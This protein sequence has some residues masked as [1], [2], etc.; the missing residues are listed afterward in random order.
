MAI[1]CVE[2]GRFERLLERHGDRLRARLFSERELEF[3]ALR[4]GTR[5]LAARFA[6]KVAARRALGIEDGL[7]GFLEV[8]V[9][10]E[11]GAAPELVLRGGAERAAAA[12]GGVRSWVSLTH[13]R[14][15]GV[16]QVLFERSV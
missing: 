12:F 3:A 6:A 7:G 10:R 11:Q 5:S 14:K 15:L 16:A 1:E 8:E 4:E 13:D 9:L 2:I